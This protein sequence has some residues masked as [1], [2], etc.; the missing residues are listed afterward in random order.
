MSA[1]KYVCN[2]A[3]IVC[4]LCTKTEGKLLVTSNTV[5]LQ[6]KFWA[7]IKDSKKPNLQFTGNCKKSDKSSVP[8]VALISPDQWKN[9]G[10]ILIQGNKALLECSTIK[11]NY[12]NAK[13]TIKDYIQKT[14]LSTIIF[15]DVD[16]ITP[17]LPIS[18][19]IISSKLTK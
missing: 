9:T 13:I 18:K 16:S 5:K 10:D 6:D 14:E 7:T 12:G 11:C 8:C 1:K 4:P 3:V 17:D 19:T 2:N 15:S